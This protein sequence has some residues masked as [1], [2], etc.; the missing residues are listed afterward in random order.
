MQ[1]MANILVEDH[2]DQV[3]GDARRYI[4]RIVANT[5]KMQALLDEL[6]KL[7]LIGRVETDFACVDLNA[8]VRDVL[9]QLHHTL[10][11]R[12]AR[13]VV[14][15]PL[16]TVQ[17]N[18]TRLMQ[19]FTNL[20]DNAVKYTPADRAPLI[21]IRVTERPEGWQVLV[22]DNGIGIA[23]AHRDRVFGLFQRLPAAKTLYPG[24]SG[25]GLAIVARIVET[26]GGELWFDSVQD[27]GTTFH[28]TLPQPVAA[29]SG[30]E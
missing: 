7:A 3:A 9:D 13:V 19:L 10:A 17:A 5:R 8:V 16:P 25:A 6:L 26:H 11:T 30:G 14:D 27:T 4:D 28:F 29:G 21:R 15:G 1:A 2:G 20:L 12:D 24:G 22:A 23:P 18:H